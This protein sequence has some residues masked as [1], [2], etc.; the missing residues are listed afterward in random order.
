ML[1]WGKPKAHVS[2]AFSGVC[3]WGLW[4]QKNLGVQTDKGGIWEVM[5]FTFSYN[6]HCWREQGTFLKF[7][8]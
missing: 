1:L 2:L 7:Q 3:Q 6:L 8:I 5:S 4:I